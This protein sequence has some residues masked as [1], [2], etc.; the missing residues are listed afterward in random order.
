[1]GLNH[2][3]TENTEKSMGIKRAL[4][5]LATKSFT[6]RRKD[7]EQEQNEWLSLRA[8]RLCAKLI[9]LSSLCS[10][11]LCGS[12]LA[13]PDPESNK[14]YKLTV[15]LHVTEHPLLTRVFKDQL[16][17]ELRDSLQDGLSTTFAEVTLVHE[18]P[19]LEEIGKRGLQQ[20]L[21]NYKSSEP[22]KTH[23]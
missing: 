1:R 16:A 11:C 22:I 20:A 21:E 19:L 7:A 3:G 12:I 13:A 2:R 10:L 4:L 8:Q 23:F 15:V 17:R 5:C 9:L 6:Q 14:P 18:H